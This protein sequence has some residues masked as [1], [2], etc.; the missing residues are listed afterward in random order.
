MT[1]VDLF[2]HQ[3][4]AE[5]LD[6]E[7]VEFARAHNLDVIKRTRPATGRLSSYELLPKATPDD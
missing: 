6:R 5:G 3:A 7:V 2:T 1:V 4:N